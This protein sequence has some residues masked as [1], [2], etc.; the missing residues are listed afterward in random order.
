LHTERINSPA[1]A[2]EFATLEWVDWFNHRR[3]F[4]QSVAVACVGGLD[5]SYQ[6][7]ERGDFDA[8]AEEEF[9]P[10][11]KFIR[12]RNEPSQ[13]LIGPFQSRADLTAGQL[14]TCV[15][16]SPT[17]KETRQGAPPLDPHASSLLPQPF[18][19]KEKRQRF[20]VK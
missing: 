7:V 4:E 6:H 19:K 17:K 11:R 20:K 12:G 14:R 9:L 16:T 10:P 5:Q 13:K 1:E 15:N 18:F 2:V 8:V 3:R